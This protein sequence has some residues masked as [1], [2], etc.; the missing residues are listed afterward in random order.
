MNGIIKANSAF[1]NCVTVMCKNYLAY[2]NILVKSDD[3][4]F[5]NQNFDMNNHLLL[6][7]GSS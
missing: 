7:I 2:F 5:H 3:Q 1:V 4:C 6:L